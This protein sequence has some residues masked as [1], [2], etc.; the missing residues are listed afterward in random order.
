MPKLSIL[1][2]V[3]NVEN[4]IKKCLNSILAQT[5]MDF[6]LILVDDGSTDESGRICDQYASENS[7]IQVLHKRNGGLASAR[8]AGINKAIGKY[9]AFVDSDDW[10]A[11]DM[12]GKFID[13][14]QKD[15]SIDICIG[16]FFQ[17][18]ENGLSENSLIPLQEG[19]ISR[20]F[21]LTSMYEYKV[22]TCSM[23]GKVYKRELFFYENIFRI[24]RDY[25]EDAA[26]NW[27]LF[28]NAKIFYYIPYAG[29]YYFL[30]DDS[31]MHTIFSL[32]R[33]DLIN[34]FVE[35][36]GDICEECSN[37]KNVIVE[38]IFVHTL[39]CIL[40]MLESKNVYQTEIEY[41]QL[42]LKEAKMIID[43]SLTIVEEKKYEISCLPYLQG[44]QYIRRF[45]KNIQQFCCKYDNIYIYGAGTVAK[46]L[47]SRLGQLDI[48][49]KGFI[50]T[51][52]Y[53]NQ[54]SCFGKKINSFEQFLKEKS[55][56]CGILIGVS[57][58]NSEEIINIFRSC[59][60]KDF[61]YVGQYGV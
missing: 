25:A 30:R 2:P 45:E 16:T 60:Y 21:A 7:R 47:A 11:P 13:V 40:Q 38:N 56:T 1:I 51:N 31:M 6:E 10:I 9:I 46:N 36:L 23:F 43:R 42:I 50:V 19:Y 37:L 58:K 17:E 28:H 24:G 33:L 3:Y 5:F 15:S 44:R 61:Y 49:Y 41:Y 12:Y 14:L 54:K 34:V 26:A 8:I 20:E 18:N 29:Y 59:G 4:Q 39:N 32:K 53:V 52:V 22:F 48:P 27:Q 57:K 55:G 35:M